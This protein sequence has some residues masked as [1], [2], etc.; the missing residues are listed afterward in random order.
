MLVPVLNVLLSVANKLMNAWDGLSK[1]MQKGIVIFAAVSAAVLLIGGTL[2]T[3][4]GLFGMFAG[5][6]AAA[7][8]GFAAIGSAIA[9]IMPVILA[10]V[11]IIVALKYAWD[12]NLGGI[13]QTVNSF[14]EWFKAVFFFTFQ[15][16]KSDVEDGIKAF[17]NAFHGMDVS[18]PVNKVIKFL[19]GDLVNGLMK[20]VSAVASGI[21][22]MSAWFKKM[23][24]QFGEAI[25][26]IVAFLVWLT[27]LWK[28][29][30]TVL[31]FVVGLVFDWIVGI[32]KHF[33]GVFSG[34]IQLIVDLIN[35]NWKAVFKDLWQ[36]VKNAFLLVLDLWGGALGKFFGF[37]AKIIERTGIFGKAFNTI[38]GGAFKLAEKAADGM[39]K[40]VE[41]IWQAGVKIVGSLLSPFHGLVGKI[42]YGIADLV[43]KHSGDA[44][45]FFQ[46]AFEAI[47]H[48]GKILL[49]GLKDYFK[50]E[51][52][53]IKL[54]FYREPAAWM[55]KLK[56]EF[57]AGVNYVKTHLTQWGQFISTQFNKVKGYI[58]DHVNAAITKMKDLFSKG[59]SYVKGVLTKWGNE[60]KSV[61][62]KVKG[63]IEVPV[64]NAL[65]FL[66][67]MFSTEINAVKTIL[68]V[69]KSL[70]NAVFTAIKDLITG[71]SDKAMSA[72]KTAFKLG[73][74]ALKGILGGIG[75]L[76]DSVL[77]GLPSKMLNWGKNAMN[78][79]V[80]GIKSGIG[81]IGSAVSSAAN[82]IKDFLGFHS[83]A[84]EGPAARGESD[85][86]MP[87]MM[88][89]L[90]K[91][92]DGNKDKIQK[93]TMGVALG[94]QQ[95]F[96]G[97]QKV[98]HQSMNGS[99]S[100]SPITTHNR[101]NSQQVVNIN[102][103]GRSVKTDQQLAENI[104]K[105]FHTQMSMVRS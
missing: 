56:T 94:I 48:V 4:I 46:K 76:I 24:P 84:K 92:I 31:K 65:K 91:G 79:F 71:H 78:M 62:D 102:I 47:L 13:R 77:G 89:M 27:P 95:T 34:I 96:S 18:G 105:Q 67:T 103:E 14:I 83:P 39:W 85:Q 50:F 80:Q 21:T 44:L 93:A 1:P 100:T 55:V 52:D 3:A 81:A 25:K 72:L 28:A 43:S 2:M 104:A 64:G 82:K 12:H 59:V 57:T 75:S 17:K 26:R 99:N 11:A 35:G 8:A 7:M 40:Y 29:L 58:T 87:N 90:A 88:N 51:F 5:S 54:L 49:T 30:W 16:V 66:K 6:M 74:T 53:I 101:S 73:V 20:V 86:W 10:V 41:K 45:K 19:T 69:F 61:Y 22:T 15:K 63:Y 60:V 9:T 37:F 98:I 33:W 36:I 97:T 23:A 68:N 32:I 38:F 42:F 70:V